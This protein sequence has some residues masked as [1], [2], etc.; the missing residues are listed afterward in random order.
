MTQPL[1]EMRGVSKRF[2]GVQALDGAELTIDPGEILAVVGENGAGKSTLMKILSGVHSPDSGTILMNGQKVQP[3]DPI[4]ARDQLGVSIIYQEF[5]LA[6]DLSVAENIFLGRL[7]TRRGFLQHDQLHRM[8]IEFLAMLG[9][10]LDPRVPVSHLSVA[11]QQMVEIAKAISYQATLLIMDEP[12]AALTSRETDALFKVA[13][14]LRDK[15]VGII[16]ITH[17]LDEVFEIA[18]RVTVLR[19]GKTVGT[20]LIGELDRGKVVRMMV[21]RDLSEIYAAKEQPVGKPL[22]EVDQ[23]SVP[24]LLDDITFKLHQ[25]EILGLFGLLGSGRTELARALFGIGPA[26]HGR[27][28]IDGRQTV[29]RSPADAT[30][31]GLAYVPE[32]RKQHG[33]VLPMSV[34]EN[35]TLSVLQSLTR[36]TMVR[37]AMERQLTDRF[38]GELD[39]RTPSREQAV[40]NLSGGNQQKV[41]LAKWLASNPRVL[42]LDEPTRGVDVGAKAEVHSIV[43]DLARK[44][45][46][47]LMISSDLPEVLHMSDR[48]LIMHEGRLTGAFSREEA[49]EELIMLAATGSEIPANARVPVGGH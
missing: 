29:V 17:R 21:G 19:D 14:G 18:D 35:S 15:G 13:R 8:A 16:F 44:G 4:H 34:R 27:V 10:D 23:L 20:R 24:H 49:T 33:L 48:V 37:P 22:L 42:I 31:I 39:I 12:T 32:D 7:P 30:K 2:P 9:T 43:A 38:I 5:N 40:N 28:R 3:R 36:L 46:G 41:V 6:K 45:V 26:P 1:L 25:G 47:I 11:Q